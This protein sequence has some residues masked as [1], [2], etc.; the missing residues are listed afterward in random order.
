MRS[1]L[2]SIDNM[3][4]ANSKERISS[5]LFSIINKLTPKISN[6]RVEMKFVKGKF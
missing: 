4:T 1:F 3:L 6:C 2:L 5:R